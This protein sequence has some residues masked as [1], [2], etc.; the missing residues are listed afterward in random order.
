MSWGKLL[1]PDLVLGD[2]I[3]QLIPDILH[4]YDLKG[5]VLDVDETLVPI[6]TQEVSDELRE[7]V[8]N[9]RPL[10]SLWLVS[11]NIS[12]TRISGIANA[13]GLPYINAAAKPSRRKLRQAVDAMD[14][15][16]AQIAMVGD[17]LFTDVLA[18]NRLG[19]FTILV[20]PMVD[21]MQ[22]GTSFST[23]S[24]EVWIS[25]LLGAVLKN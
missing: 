3:M 11:N 23:R 4:Q 22:T 7:W 25:K 1:E 9:V 18:G 8:E 20:E 15:P 5:L 12:Q 16:T 24:I 21:P 2:S 13:L 10:F 19:M 17:R 14:I 6:T